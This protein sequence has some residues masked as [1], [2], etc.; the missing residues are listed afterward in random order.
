M[1]VA[2]ASGAKRIADFQVAIWNVTSDARLVMGTGEEFKQ[3]QL[4]AP[5]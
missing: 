2:T 4:G 5:E 3:N 1:A